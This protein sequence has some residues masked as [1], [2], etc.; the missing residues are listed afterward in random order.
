MS[1]P[2]RRRRH[3]I[4]P[5]AG[6][7]PLLDVIFLLLFALMIT[8]ETKSDNKSELVPIELP[9]VQPS[10]DPKTSQKDPVRIVLDSESR[11]R[12]EPNQ[13]TLN[14]LDEVDTALGTA[15]GDALPEEVDVQIHADRNARHG[16]AIELL[17]HLRVR[18]FI[19]VQLV[20]LGQPDPSGVFLQVKSETQR[21]GGG[22]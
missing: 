18:G 5:M 9:E 8:S 4:S 20:A 15:L 22:R 7:T 1:S 12:L 6:L 2:A 11:V 17:Q 3:R 10:G 16:V 19:R 14:S 13:T 21:E